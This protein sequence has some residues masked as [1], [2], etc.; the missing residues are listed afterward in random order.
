L[1][2]YISPE[3]QSRLQFRS[4][5]L[6][7]AFFLVFLHCQIQ[8][9]DMGLKPQLIKARAEGLTCKAILSSRGRSCNGYL[10][11]EALS[12]AGTNQQSLVRLL[13]NMSMGRTK[14]NETFLNPCELKYL[15]CATS[16]RSILFNK[17]D[18]HN[19]RIKNSNIRGHYFFEAV[20]RILK[21]Y[22]NKTGSVDETDW[23]L[24]PLENPN[25]QTQEI[26]KDYLSSERGKQLNRRSYPYLLLGAAS[27]C[28]SDACRQFR[29]KVIE[30]A[31]NGMQKVAS[32]PSYRKTAG[33]LISMTPIRKLE[34]DG[35][36]REIAGC[37]ARQ[38]LDECISRGVL[39]TLLARAWTKK[40]GV[41]AE[42]DRFFQQEKIRKLDLIS[43]RNEIPWLQ[44]LRTLS[45]FSLNREIW[46]EKD[47]NTVLLIL[48]RYA[49]YLNAVNNREK[50][51]PASWQAIWYDFIETAL[52]ENVHRFNNQTYT[53]GTYLYDF[54]SISGAVGKLADLDK[55]TWRYDETRLEQ[56]SLMAKRIERY[57]E[58]MG[59]NNSPQLFAEQTLDTLV[60]S[61]SVFKRSENL[62]LI[63]RRDMLQYYNKYNK[64]RSQPY[65]RLA[66]IN[67]R[68]FEEA[69]KFQR[70]LMELEFADL[71]ARRR[72]RDPERMLEVFQYYVQQGADLFMGSL[73]PGKNAAFV[74]YRLKK[75]I[76]N[77]DP[78]YINGYI[79]RMYEI[80]DS[81]YQNGLLMPFN[82]LLLEWDKMHRRKN[83]KVEVVFSNILLNQYVVKDLLYSGNRQQNRNKFKLRRI[84]KLWFSQ[85]QRNS[86]QETN[87]LDLF[88]SQEKSHQGRTILYWKLRQ[89]YLNKL[90]L[91]ILTT[92][93]EVFPSRYSFF[94]VLGNN[95]PFGYEFSKNLSMLVGRNYR[96]LKDFSHS[97]VMN[98]IE[99][100]NPRFFAAGRADENLEFDEDKGNREISTY[101]DYFYNNWYRNLADR[102]VN[103]SSTSIEEADARR[104]YMRPDRRLYFESVP[105]TNAV[106]RIARN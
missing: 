82:A 106:E 4:V 64:E 86:H 74:G 55:P 103:V 90:D 58:H 53:C 7:S 22:I 24:R 76:Q 47:L 66:R 94:A 36:A 69:I 61:A 15:L 72:D 52:R 44:D 48:S 49:S 65:R 32:I 98:N 79:K 42:T 89:S 62:Q 87:P 1:I 75:V 29:L 57:V 104:V 68:Y 25:L 11:K 23:F 26:L 77:R 60:N 35:S 3:R 2:N 71:A 13:S 33:D 54:G 28:R 102:V 67:K 40:L 99:L 70:Q 6:Y 80:T 91:L 83:R 5:L 85:V 59:D 92:W 51:K 34:T 21:S 30:S 81:G 10:S 93:G 46:F 37:S 31:F 50:L 43:C 38:T 84:S 20:L 105:I 100:W 88:R 63:R 41:D 14:Y 8:S 18:A 16:Q 78:E 19:R 39:K 56:N 17:Y 9:G 73:E 96:F 97:E 12:N 27:Q 95:D 101:W 45:E